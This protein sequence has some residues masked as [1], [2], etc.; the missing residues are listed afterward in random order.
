[1]QKRCYLIF[2]K[3]ISIYKN[4][5]TIIKLNNKL[6][7]LLS[8]K[9]STADKLKI[10]SKIDDSDIIQLLKESLSSKDF[11]LSKLSKMLLNRK[12]LKIEFSDK[13][14]NKALIFN[15]IKNLKKKYGVNDEISS[16]FIFTDTISNKLYDENEKK[17]ED[18]KKKWRY[19]KYF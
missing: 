4:L 5:E 17:I 10:F 19:I 18:T 9:L 1:M 13:K 8:D 16:Y 11:V 14:F 2:S 6:K 12:L 15:H 7:E 3:D